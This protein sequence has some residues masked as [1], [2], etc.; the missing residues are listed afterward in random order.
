MKDETKSFSDTYEGNRVVGI[1]Q[2][3]AADA[4]RAGNTY[5]TKITL[6]QRRDT[7]DG[8]SGTA[9]MYDDGH[10]YSEAGQ[11]RP[12]PVS[13]NKKKKDTEAL[14]Q[15]SNPDDADTYATHAGNLKANL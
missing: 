10:V 7:F 1:D 14:N 9:S 4:W 13:E 12:T 15:M 8:D 5:P 3:E 6:N 11:F 2:Q